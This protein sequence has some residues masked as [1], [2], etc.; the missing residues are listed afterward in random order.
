MLKTL[1]LGLGNPL[2]TDDGVMVLHSIGRFGSAGFANY[3]RNFRNTG[4]GHV[5]LLKDPFILS[6]TGVWK[7]CWHQQK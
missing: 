7:G 5:E 1:V 2:L 3:G 6:N 4:Y